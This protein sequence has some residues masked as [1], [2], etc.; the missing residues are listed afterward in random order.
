MPVYQPSLLDILL[1]SNC[2]WCIFF[3]FWA[4]LWALYPHRTCESHKNLL[5]NIYSHLH[6]KTFGYWIFSGLV[7]AGSRLTAEET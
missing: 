7:I 2:R 5:Q 4:V 1:G 3:A 6:A